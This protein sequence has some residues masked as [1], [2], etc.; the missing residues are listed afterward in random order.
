M[1]ITTVMIMIQ[2]ISQPSLSNIS[3]TIATVPW[4]P[5]VP[6]NS[7]LNVIMQLKIAF[8]FVLYAVI[9]PF[10]FSAAV[11]RAEE[12]KALAFLKRKKERKKVYGACMELRYKHHRSQ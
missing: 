6:S 12:K 11:V 1:M 8:I 4:Q 3:S 10:H 9:I 5:I 7:K 2:Q